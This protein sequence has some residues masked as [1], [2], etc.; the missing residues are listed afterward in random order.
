MTSRSI[1]SPSPSI[2]EMCANVKRMGYAASSRVRLYGEDFE[3]LSDPFPELAGRRSCQSDERLKGLR[4]ESSRD[5]P[6]EGKRSGQERR[7]APDRSFLSHSPRW[8]VDLCTL[9]QPDNSFRGYAVSIE[10][11]NSCD[12]R[13]SGLFGRND[14]DAAL[15]LMFGSKVEKCFQP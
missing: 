6:S 11:M 15:V 10:E 9:D 8:L 7:L 5:N 3:V 13:C 14:S 4:A 1:E 2:L 12:G